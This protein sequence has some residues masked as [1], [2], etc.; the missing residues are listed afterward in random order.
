[1]GT[2]VYCDTDERIFYLSDEIDNK[3]IGAMCF[4]LLVMLSKDDKE[5]KEKKDF[6]RKPIHIYVNSFGGSVYDMWAL[7]DIIQ[8]SK[9]P[10]YTYCTGM[11]MSAAFLIFIAGHKRFMSLNATLLYH[12]SSCWY[13]YK[14]QDLVEGKSE[15][16][17]VQHN[18]EEF[19]VKRTTMTAKELKNIRERKQDVFLHYE[20][21]LEKGM[22]D[23]LIYAR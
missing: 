1:M 6:T 11:A 16:D 21:A 3:S 10:I 22:V 12:Q 14:Y 9:T 4:N 13:F 5:E 15:M 8:N 18:I 2:N 20:E 7:I 17:W 23:D 19:V